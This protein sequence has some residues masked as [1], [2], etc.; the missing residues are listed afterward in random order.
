MSMVGWGDIVALEIRRNI[1]IDYVW[2]VQR[3]NNA[4]KGGHMIGF[5]LIG[6]GVILLGIAAALHIREWEEKHDE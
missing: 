3:D 2:D 5:I 1:I 6:A 4:Q